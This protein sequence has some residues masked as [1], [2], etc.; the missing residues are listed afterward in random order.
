MQHLTTKNPT[1]KRLLAGAATATLL[2][3]GLTAC[4]DD[5]ASSK[6]KRIAQI[7]HLTGRTTAVN[8]TRGSSMLS[9]V[10]S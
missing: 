3:F 8:S 1:S 2:A 6:P 4:S 5:S 7:D 10:L 9:R